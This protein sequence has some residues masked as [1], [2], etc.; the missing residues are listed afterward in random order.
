MIES[1]STYDE[2]LAKVQSA[3]FVATEYVV[4]GVRRGHIVARDPAS[5]AHLS[6]LGPAAYVIVTNFDYWW[7]DVRE[8]FDPATGRRILNA[9]LNARLTPGDR[10]GRRRARGRR[11]FPARARRGRAVGDRAAGAPVNFSCSPSIEAKKS[12][13]ATASRRAWPLTPQDAASRCNL[14]RRD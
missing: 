1:I 8:Y 2:A 11:V 4:V 9:S 14:L 5:V 12:F 13:S 7:H 3:H 10:G 6:T